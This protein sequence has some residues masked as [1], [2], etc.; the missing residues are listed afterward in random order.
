MATN[1]I[2]GEV[3]S[4]VIE[5]GLVR[6]KLIAGVQA[7]VTPNSEV[8]APASHGASVG[9]DVAISRNDSTDQMATSVVVSA[10]YVRQISEHVAAG[11]SNSFTAEQ[12]GHL[13]AQPSFSGFATA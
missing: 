13:I 5:V 4:S 7:T 3:S 8:R 9:V 1:S 10:T 2:S 11:V 12:I 6:F